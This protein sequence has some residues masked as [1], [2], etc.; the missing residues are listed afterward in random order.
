MTSILSS[1]R[2][3][4][5]LGEF[6]APKG[7]EAF[8]AYAI[9]VGEK[10]VPEMENAARQTLNFP[11]T[12]EI[13]GEGLLLFDA[14]ALQDLANFCKRCRDSLIACLGLFLQVQPP[15]PSTIWVGCPRGKPKERKSL[16]SWQEVSDEDE[17]EVLPEWLSQ[18]L[19][20]NQNNLKLQEFA[21]SLDIHSKIREKYFAALQNHG[22]CYFCL[23]VHIRDG[24]GF[25]T[26]LRN[27]LVRARDKVVL[28]L[29]TFQVPRDLLLVGTQ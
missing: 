3:K 9:A 26:E 15:G 29:F 2:A 16:Y 12:F 6:P 7:A 27:K 14:G 24:S 1:I 11:M 21:H 4:V 23:S 5:R 25:W 19:L 8:S 28:I 17:E 13:L 20:L 10:L 22:N 18:F